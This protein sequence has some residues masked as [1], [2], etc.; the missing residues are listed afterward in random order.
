MEKLKQFHK[1][2]RNSENTQFPVNSFTPFAWTVGEKAWYKVKL[3]YHG[4]LSDL[5]M[6]STFFC[7]AIPGA[8]LQAESSVQTDMQLI[9]ALLYA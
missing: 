2:S 4:A 6:F 5:N 8:E 7:N 1:Y 9:G 3:R